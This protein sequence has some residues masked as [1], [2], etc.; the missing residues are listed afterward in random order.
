MTKQEYL[1]LSAQIKIH[2]LSY[3]INSGLKS[4]V[5]LIGFLLT[6]NQLGYIK[7]QE[8][9][10]LIKIFNTILFFGFLLVV[11]YFIYACIK[12]SKTERLRLK[13]LKD[14]Y[15]TGETAEEILTDFVFQEY[16]LEK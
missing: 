6:T 9:F 7:N 1:Q 13:K 10:D 2:H 5:S 4:I 8:F 3:R 12:G 16:F 15:I 14:G 11:T